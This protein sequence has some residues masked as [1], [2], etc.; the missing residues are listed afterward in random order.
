MVIM[1]FEQVSCNHCGMDSTEPFAKLQDWLCGIEGEFYLVRCANCGLVYQNPRPDVAEIARFYPSEYEPYVAAND[2]ASIIQKRAL[3][4]GMDRRC[5]LIRHWIPAGRLLDVGCS[6]GL[7]LN[8]M[9]H[10]GDWELTGVELNEAVAQQARQQF[11]L[12]VFAGQLAEAA[13]PDAHF[14]VVTLWDVLEHLHDPRAALQEIRRILKPGGIVI[15]RTPQ[16][17]S[18]DGWLFGNYWI[19]LDAPR[20]LYIFPRPVMTRMLNLAGFEI[21]QQKCW[22]G[23]FGFVYSMDFWLRARGKRLDK[24]IEHSLV[25]RAATLPLF[26]A[27]DRLGRGTSITIV[28]RAI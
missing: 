11:N 8:R 6:S 1:A 26:W 3:D 14:D 20:H 27:I 23:Y 2:A 18:L 21:I 16:L 4:F 22:G 15:I 28:A 12:D 17:E 7:V 24:R 13:F 5:R 25:L 10:Y 19:G 9:R